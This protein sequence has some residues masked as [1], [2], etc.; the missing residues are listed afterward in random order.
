VKK[1]GIEQGMSVVVLH[2]PEHLESLLDPLPDGVTLQ[3]TL[4][5]GCDMLIGFI[6]E[7]A[8]LERNLPRLL[9]ALPQEGA[10]WIAWPKRS[11]GVTT[12]MSDHAVR[13]L[14]LPTGWVDTKVCS[15]DETWSALKLVLR[16]ELR[17]AHR[18]V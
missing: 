2:A 13:D 12:D 7:R 8:H 14:V 3:D 11:S 18:Q 17:S 16:K 1:L 4:R 10:L 5:S 9:N 15:I 6:T